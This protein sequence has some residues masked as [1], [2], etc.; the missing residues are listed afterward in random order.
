MADVLGDFAALPRWWPS[1]YLDIWECGRRMRR[2]SAGGSRPSRRG[3]CR[4]R[5]G[6]SSRS[7]SRATR[8][9][10]PSSPAAISTGAACGPSNSDGSMVEM[11]YDW[12][13]RAEKPLLRNLSFLLKPLFEANHRWAMAKGEESLKL[14]LARRRATSDAARASVPAPPGPVTYAGVAIVAGAA[15]VGAG[16]AYLLVRSRRRRGR[17]AEAGRYEDPPTRIAPLRGARV[18]SVRLQPD[19]HFSSSAFSEASARSH[20]WPDD[21]VIPAPPRA[22]FESCL[23]HADAGP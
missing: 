19:A 22:L 6:G 4:T 15:A 14:E 18:R 3:G 12:R 5:S 9:A 17:P 11:T 23:S 16:L 13:L 2:A 20:P 21:L 10:S 8:T 1:V 7:S